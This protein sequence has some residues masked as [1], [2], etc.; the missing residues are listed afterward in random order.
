[1]LEDQ[2]NAQVP[3][4]IREQAAERL[5]AF[6]EEIDTINEKLRMAMAGQFE[7]AADRHP[8]QRRS[9]RNVQGKPHWSRRHGPGPR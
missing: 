1:M 4:Q 8:G 5:A 9:T 2:I 3:D 6:Q 7:P